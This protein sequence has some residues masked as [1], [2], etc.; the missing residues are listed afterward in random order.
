V[1]QWR[2]LSAPSPTIAVSGHTTVCGVA[3]GTSWSHPGQRYDLVDDE[4]RMGRTT[5]GSP[6]QSTVVSTEGTGPLGCRFGR[7]LLM[8]YA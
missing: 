8:A 6:R 7:R 1:C 4:P 3:G 5:Q 2:L